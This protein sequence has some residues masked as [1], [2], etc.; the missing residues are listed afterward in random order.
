MAIPVFVTRLAQH[1][2]AVVLQ[3]LGCYPCAHA[4]AAA[5]RHPGCGITCPPFSIVADTLA[6]QSD[7]G[8]V[9]NDVTL[10]VSQML[11]LNDGAWLANSDNLEIRQAIHTIEVF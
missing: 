2:V 1:R 10:Q 8:V 7:S 5:N 6:V 11:T 9:G 3:A 4:I